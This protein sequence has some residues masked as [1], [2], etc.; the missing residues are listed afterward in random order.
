MKMAPLRS[1]TDISD[2]KTKFG[3]EEYSAERFDRSS[4]AIL[5]S[6]TITMVWPI[7]VIELM[8][9]KSTWMRQSNGVVLTDSRIALLETLP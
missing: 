9:P 6:L 5:A 1:N 8:G 4:I 2:A 7:T 3:R